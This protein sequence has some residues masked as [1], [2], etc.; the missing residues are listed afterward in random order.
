MA[1]FGARRKIIAISV[2]CAQNIMWIALTILKNG[3]VCFA[4]AKSVINCFVFK[5]L[6]KCAGSKQDINL[7]AWAIKT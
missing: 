3:S 5:S 6:C 7:Q 2:P 1:V 4:G